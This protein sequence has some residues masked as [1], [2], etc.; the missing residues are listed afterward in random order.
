MKI[1]IRAER[2]KDYKAIREV[3]DLAFGQTSESKLIETLRLTESFVPELSL[4]AE[5]ED[6]I[7]GHILFYPVKIPSGKDSYTSL[8]LA[9]LAVSPDYQR[10]GIGSRLIIEGL[11]VAKRL[12]YGS[13]IVVGH[14][15]FYAMFGFQPAS[16]WNIKASFDVSDD[17]FLALEIKEGSLN[18]VSG[19]VDYPE[20]FNVCNS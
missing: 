14:P 9:P 7:V 18:N 4:V 10:K 1:S 20:E 13:V 17:A 12:G 3:N 19:T 16:K 15:E 6:K 11:S 8:A 5:R 2:K